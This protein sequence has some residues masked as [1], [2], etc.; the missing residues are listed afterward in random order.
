[1]YCNAGTARTNIIGDL[2]G[3]RPVWFYADG[4]AILSLF[5][6]AQRI[7]V[8]YD[9]H[10]DDTLTVWKG[11]GNVRKFRP[12]PR[13]LYYFDSREIEGTALGVDEEDPDT[14][15]TAE[16]NLAQHNRRQVKDATTARYFQNKAGLST[17]ALLK[18][19]DSGAL[20]NHLSLEKQ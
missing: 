19:V 13:D 7:H 4:I 11:D 16:A 10:T 9:S 12:G 6:V 14:I 1:M 8:Q 18:M 17:R 20:K 3:Y 15:N 5:H 2:K